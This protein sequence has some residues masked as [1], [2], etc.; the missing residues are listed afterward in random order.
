M[1]VRVHSDEIEKAKKAALGYAWEDSAVAY[2]A[3]AESIAVDAAMKVFEKENHWRAEI[4]ALSSPGKTLDEMA[5]SLMPQQAVLSSLDMSI[6]ASAI[7]NIADQIYAKSLDAAKAA[8]AH[9]LG[10]MAWKTAEEQLSFVVPPREAPTASVPP[11]LCWTGNM[12][13]SL[14]RSAHRPSWLPRM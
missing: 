4:E 9:A 14:R 12:S 5:K 3:A 7:T 13:I 2:R 6:G 11:F 1:A 8:Q 10:G